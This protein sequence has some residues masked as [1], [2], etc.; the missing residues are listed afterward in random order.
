MAGPFP[1]SPEFIFNEGQPWG[2]LWVNMEDAGYVHQPSGNPQSWAGR[3]TEVAS[4]LGKRGGCHYTKSQA[5]KRHSLFPET[6]IGLILTMAIT[7]P[8]PGRPN[9][10]AVALCN[11]R[12]AGAP[13]GPKLSIQWLWPCSPFCEREGGGGLPALFTSHPGV[14]LCL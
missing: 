7:R 11:R 14:C 12:G 5:E 2:F 10:N 4:L 3:A 6:Y 9:S 13:G 8:Y 1:C